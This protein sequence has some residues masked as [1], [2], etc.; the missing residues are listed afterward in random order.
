M[1]G[2]YFIQSKVNDAKNS[3]PLNKIKDEI[4]SFEAS[5]LHAEIINFQPIENGLRKSFL[6]KGIFASLPFL[7]V[8]SYY[9]YKPEFDNKNF[10]YIRFEAAD[11]PFRKFLKKLRK[12][13]P[14]AKIV[15]EF[16]DFPN[17]IW[18]KSIFYAGIFLKDFYARKFYKKYIDR[19]AVWN[20]DYKEIYGVK[21]VSYKNGI[22]VDRIPIKNHLPHI[23]GSLRL[24]A[25]GSMFRFHG[26]DRLLR[27]L[28]IYYES[29][30]TKVVYID[31]VG[32]DLGG[33]RK[34]YE[35]YVVQNNLS[36]YVTFYGRKEGKELAELFDKCDIAVSSLGMYRIGF[37][38]ASSLKSRE[39]LA[40]GIPIVAGCPID[41]IHNTD[42]NYCIEFPNDNSAINIDKI[43]EWY[44][45]LL[46][47]KSPEEMANEIRDFAKKNCDTSVV[48][49]NVI[50]YLKGDLN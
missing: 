13:N 1:N 9:E 19:F 40:R 45:S 36:E 50:E 37:K 8:F 48:M 46:V 14:S 27:G 20:D 16:P 23:N 7:P 42:F 24:I 31:I 22:E 33:E 3:G 11:Y 34:K 5:C 32:S 4:S 29:S 26:F 47:S 15:I 25:I 41:V 49:N 39:Y 30:H 28:K 35:K 38:Y 18:M 12:N 17:T 43:I 44:D 10:Y 6:G 2:I 21:T